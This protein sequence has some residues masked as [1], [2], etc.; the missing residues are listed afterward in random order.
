GESGSDGTFQ[1]PLERA[2]FVHAVAE[3]A[4][5]GRGVNLG[6]PFGH[7]FTIT[8]GD[9]V[10]VE[11]KVTRDDG[12]PVALAKV[13]IADDATS[14]AGPLGTTTDSLGHYQLEHVAK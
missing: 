5:L 12:L 11:G 1:I 4:G 10:T 2:I 14:L 8:L 3:R 7:P 6:T 13:E 9:G